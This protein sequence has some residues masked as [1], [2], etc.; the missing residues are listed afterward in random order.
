VIAVDANLLL[1]AK[2]LD[3][4]QHEAARD[5][6]D[7]A[8]A[9]APRVALPWPSVLAFMRIA[10]NP[11]VFGKPLSSEAAWKQAQEWLARPNV[12]VP[13]PTPRH[14]EVLGQLVHAVHPTGKLV[15]DAHLAVLAI[16]HGLV[17]CTT[18]ADF[19]RF[20]GLRWENPLR[21][22]AAKG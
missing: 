3:F 5:W 10:T 21:G 14:A 12:W 4:P 22:A 13:V 9:G 8:I 1:Y 7:H 18:D 2:F 16:E 15:P 17:L 11:R 6:L 19:G 20:P